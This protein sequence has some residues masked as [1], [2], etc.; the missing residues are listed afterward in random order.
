MLFLQCY[1]D[2]I[3]ATAEWQFTD[4]QHLATWIAP[5]GPQIFYFLFCDPDE[6][7][8]LRFAGVAPPNL[9]SV[10][11]KR[12]TLDNYLEKADRICGADE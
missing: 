2:S 1:P 10:L 11:L 12:V 9:R 8:V 6:W 5:I 4:G 7:T 3:A